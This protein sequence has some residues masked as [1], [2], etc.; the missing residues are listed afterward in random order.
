MG[1]TVLD[2]FI[3]NKDDVNETRLR[4]C[5]QFLANWKRAKTGFTSGCTR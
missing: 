2:A 5:P 3:E 4:D 1:G